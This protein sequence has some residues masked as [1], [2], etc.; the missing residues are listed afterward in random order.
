MLVTATVSND[1]RDTITNKAVSGNHTVVATTPLAAKPPASSP[2]A[3]AASLGTALAKTGDALK[4][5]WWIAALATAG[6][7]C[8]IA[9]RIRRQRS[10]RSRLK[11][12]L[13]RWTLPG[14]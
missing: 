11:R 4:D 8:L 14:R 9:F 13:A 5:H 3:A 10:A 1:A 12:S 6:A 2:A 7:T